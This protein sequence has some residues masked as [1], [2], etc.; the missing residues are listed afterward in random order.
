VLNI[1]SK[2]PWFIGGMPSVIFRRWALGDSGG[3]IPEL[4]LLADWFAVH[5]VAL[6]F[7]MCYLHEPL[8]AFRIMPNSFGRKIAIQPEKV[9]QNFLSA[10]RLLEDPKNR[11]VFPKSFVEANQRNFSY[12]CFRGNFVD[13]HFKFRKDLQ[14]LAPPKTVIDRWLGR[15]MYGFMR[16][17]QLLLKIYCFRNIPAV[18][19]KKGTLTKDEVREDGL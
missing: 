4:G 15:I 10:L 2:K 13:W 1:L 7:G 16:M 14:R 19:Y 12:A 9:M 17:E 5:Y 6:K 8:A 3:S 18:F 11:Q